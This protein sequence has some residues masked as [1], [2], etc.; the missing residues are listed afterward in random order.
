MIQKGVISID[1]VS[2]KM[3]EVETRWKKDRES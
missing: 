3:A 2:R 1:E